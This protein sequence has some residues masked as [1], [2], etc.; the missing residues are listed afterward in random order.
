MVSLC[1]TIGKSEFTLE[2][3]RQ[4]LRK[5]LLDF[6]S[7]LLRERLTTAAAAAAPFWM[8]A[9]PLA[10][11]SEEESRRNTHRSVIDFKVL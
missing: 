2:L 6:V 10:L 11:Q 1:M 4:H 5:E 8:C 9:R 7:D 3:L